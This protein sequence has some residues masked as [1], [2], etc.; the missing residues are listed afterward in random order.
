MINN[1]KILHNSLAKL[2]L[3]LLLITN[4][5]IPIKAHCIKSPDILPFV[6]NTFFIND[7]HTTSE[8]PY[9]FRII[10]SLNISGSSEFTLSQLVNIKNKISNNNVVIVDLRQESHGFVNDVPFSIYSFYELINNGLDTDKTIDS[11]KQALK[12][13]KK[14]STV[15]IFNKEPVLE[16]TITVN[17]VKSESD[18]VNG[19]GLDYRRFSVRDGSIPSTKVVDD[20]VNFIKELPSTTHIHFHCL[21]GEGR[22]TTFMALHQ[23]MKNTEKLSLDSILNEQ[24]NVGGIVLTNNKSRHKFLEYFYEYSLENIS[25]NFKTPYSEWLSTKSST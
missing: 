14:D 22:T 12:S 5:A 2:L 18:I 19:Y 17:E 10:P 23:M 11:E 24:I 1:K 21:E 3:M 7:V 13:I 6:E 9:K 25:T 8:L 15:L 4:T 16:K 20:F